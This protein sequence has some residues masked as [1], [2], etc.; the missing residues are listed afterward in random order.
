[1]Q[2]QHTGPAISFVTPHPAG[3]TATASN[4]NKTCRAARP[5]CACCVCCPILCALQLHP[6][7]WAVYCPDAELCLNQMPALLHSAPGQS[8]FV[9]MACDA[10]AARVFASLF[11]DRKCDSP[12]WPPAQMS[13]PDD[14][15][16]YLV[17]VD[18]RSRKAQCVSVP[19]SLAPS[20]IWQRES[21][22]GSCNGLGASVSHSMPLVARDDTVGRLRRLYA[23]CSV[24]TSPRSA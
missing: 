6:T 22:R 16:R 15:K 17:R 23:T 21:Y 8:C 14:K 18:P 11:S 19:S 3:C 20:K 24:S 5:R 9:M 2:H 13:W 7:S 4:I 12:S 10:C 1:M